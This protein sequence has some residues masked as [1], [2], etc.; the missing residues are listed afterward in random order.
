VEL[1]AAVS[2]DKSREAGRKRWR[3]STR[4][5]SRA[6]R[7]SSSSP[8][9]SATRATSRIAAEGLAA[10]RRFD[11]FTGAARSSLAPWHERGVSRFDEVVARRG[12]RARERL[13]RA[14]V[15]VLALLA[16]CS[17]R[18]SRPP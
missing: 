1:V 10:E 15:V 8:T 14:R 6:R 7:S 13:M 16:R 5:T 18:P 11:Y 12:A 2:D 9:G 4:R 3:S 17:S